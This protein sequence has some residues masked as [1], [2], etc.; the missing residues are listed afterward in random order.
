MY[1]N[2]QLNNIRN[3]TTEQRQLGLATAIAVVTGELDSPASD[4]GAWCASAWGVRSRA[5]LQHF[6]RGS[7][8]RAHHI[9]VGLLYDP[10]PALLDVAIVLRGMLAQTVHVLPRRVCRG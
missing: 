8:S 4:P 2:E 5:V 7:L 10:M 6:L 1:L 3:V 9:H